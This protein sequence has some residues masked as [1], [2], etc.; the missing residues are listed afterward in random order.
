MQHYSKILVCHLFKKTCTEGYKSMRKCL[1]DTKLE[2]RIKKLSQS[3]GL[4]EGQDYEL[5]FSKTKNV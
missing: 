3:W 2:K 5:P 4:Y 1:E